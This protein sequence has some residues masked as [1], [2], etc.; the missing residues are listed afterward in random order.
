MNFYLEH[1]Q[2]GLLCFSSLFT[3]INPF[4]ILPIYLTMTQNITKQQRK[5]INQKGLIAAGSI[6]IIFA[7]LGEFIFSIY[8]ITIEAF[9]IAG[10]IIFFRIGLSNL[11]SK[12]SRIKSTPMEEKEALIKNGFAFTPFAIPFIAGPG[13]ISSSMIL[14]NSADTF[15][16]KI[17]FIISIFL[18]LIIT[19]FIFQAAGRVSKKLGTIGIRI[20]QRIMGLL[21]CVIAVQFI[22]DGVAIIFE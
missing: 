15:V 9:K 20:L 5:D 12:I 4:G 13:S 19:Y 7:F 16:K 3:L 17:T 8:G 14:S 21:L 22:I 18:C 1:F 10:G 11:E 2:Y 6:L